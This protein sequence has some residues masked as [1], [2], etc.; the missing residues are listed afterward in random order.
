MTTITNQKKIFMMLAKKLFWGLFFIFGFLFSDLALAQTSNVEAE[1][2]FSKDRDMY[3]FRVNLRI[4]KQRQ[5]Q[6]ASR[7]VY[8][9]KR[10]PNSYETGKVK[11]FER[12]LW[13]NL[14]SGKVIIG[15]FL[16]AD[17][18]LMAHELY[19][20]NN[21]KQKLQTDTTKYDQQATYYWYAL[22]LE[23]SLRLKTYS[24]LRMPARVASGT[25]EEFY[26]ALWEGLTFRQ[27]IVGPFKSQI[28]AEESKRLYRLD[29]KG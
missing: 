20:L 7:E 17:Q 27:L 23:Q 15:P 3:W 28:R 14:S 11:E 10:I 22:K 4:E 24:L 16:E 9:V 8:K 26:D 1:N 18:A 6:F 19:N 25:L 2:E 12:S 13:Q 29:E 21:T 5:N